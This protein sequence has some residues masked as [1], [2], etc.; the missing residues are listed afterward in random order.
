ML[1]NIRGYYPNYFL[2]AV[3][4]LVWA[5]AA[6]RAVA[7]SDSIAPFFGMFKGESITDPR[8]LLT[9][10]DIDV[11]IWQTNRGFA[12]NWHSVVVENGAIERASHKVRFERTHTSGIYR[13][14]RPPNIMGNARSPDPI[15]GNPY[16]WAR[17]ADNTLTVYLVQI[18]PDGSVDLRIYL[19]KLAGNQ[20]QLK[21]T[22]MRDGQPLATT[23]GVLRRK[24]K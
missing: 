24:V 7:S 18:A 23:Y 13:A 17:L 5:M 4:L 21:L 14:H 12:I 16:Y 20:I 3:G 22:R 15:D 6:G 8:G 11:S 19:R 10:K 9:T 2:L 1:S